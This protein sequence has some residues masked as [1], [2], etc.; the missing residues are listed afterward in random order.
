MDFA[1]AAGQNPRGPLGHSQ[2]TDASAAAPADQQPRTISP[3]VTSAY[4]W[5]RI[6]AEIAKWEVRAAPCE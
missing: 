2:G 3:L 1:N 5:A 6:L 4:S